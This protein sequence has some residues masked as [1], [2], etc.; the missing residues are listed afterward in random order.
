MTLQGLRRTLAPILYPISLIYGFIV[1]FR[2]FLFDVN[3]LRS[4]EFNFPVISVGNITVGGTGKTPHIEYLIRLLSDRYNVAL[5]SRGY[6]RKTH[7]F[8]L[9]G[10]KTGPAEIGDEPF[11][12]YSKF[13]DITVAVDSNRV[14]GIK[15]LRQKS[16]NNNVI[17]L[18]D[19]FQ[20]RYVKPGVSI[21]LID[22]DRPVFKDRLL[23]SGDL[24]ET[25]EALERA[26]IVII[27]KV[28]LGIK[29]IEKRIWIKELKLYPYQFLYFT[30]FE[31]GDPV[32][33]FPNKQNNIVLEDLKNE[34]LGILLVSGIAT[35][36]TLRTKIEQYN[37]KV[38]TIFYPDHH[39]FT[40]KDALTLSNKFD[41]LSGKQK[42]F[43]T[44]EKDAVKLRKLKNI[45]RRL[46][47]KMY[48][49][50]IE[51]KFIDG[52]QEEFDKNVL[53]YVKNN[54]KI[55]RLNR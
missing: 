26:N 15:N 4:T 33:L 6:K 39:D 42:I 45:S 10:P 2:N 9:A 13:R 53:E 17:L 32:P 46:K 7:G 8:L 25:T 50:P 41:S 23:P 55:S 40:E 38:E 1:S 37:T 47:E 29:P 36:L 14:R 12:I 28:P 11:Q 48:Y 51:I 19:A 5:L 16:K 18:D 43:I 24:R 35:P 21:L 27:T 34:E 52:W 30:C 31:Y 22:H 54:R 3:I 44:T 20:H 49:I